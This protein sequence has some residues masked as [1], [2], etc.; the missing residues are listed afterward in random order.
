MFQKKTSFLPILVMCSLFV[1]SFSVNADKL[2]NVLMPDAF[3]I[4]RID[5]AEIQSSS[6]G[7]LIKK[8]DTVS[9]EIK[10][11]ELNTILKKYNLSDKDF[12]SFVFGYKLDLE[13]TDN[14]DK[15]FQNAENQKFV[16]GIQISK[17]ISL[18]QLK[19]IVIDSS[20]LQNKSDIDVKIKTK[21][22][23]KYL[24]LTEK[25]NKTDQP[26]AL[27]VQKKEQIIIGGSPETIIN[28][29]KRIE[30]GK[31][32]VFNAELGKL[33]SEVSNNADFYLLGYL[34]KGTRD[35]LGLNQKQDQEPAETAKNK[36]APM[37][38]L[39]NIK[40]LSI[41]ADFTAKFD[42]NIFLY[43]M[44]KKSAE[45]AHKLFNQYLPVLKFMS[46]SATKGI[47]LPMI[48]TIKCKLL[49]NTGKLKINFTVTKQD[50]KNIQEIAGTISKSD[51]AK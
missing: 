28:A 4:G 26:L 13:E 10:V 24:L 46:T 8:D 23:I 16:F 32:N 9:S 22:G 37:E 33:K 45:D 49:N 12:T 6:F 38:V 20:K 14:F 11:D 47:S 31:N 2:E 35:N 21:E 39:M 3:V 44:N 51:T 19:N 27:T 43:F 36:A 17:P 41:Q 1:S 25:G 18:K 42:A 50:V 29:V 34:P 7:K 30:R 48:D 5:L 40:A 15:A